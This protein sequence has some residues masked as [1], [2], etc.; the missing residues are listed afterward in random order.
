MGGIDSAKKRRL[1]E[2][3]GILFEGGGLPRMSG[4]VFGWLL[5]S[6]PQHQTAAE[7]AAGVG[8]SKGS[9]STM[10]RMLAQFR[11]IER[12]G[13]PGER[14]AHYRVKPAYWVSMM[15]AKMDFVRR[16]H[17]LAERALDAIDDSDA[18]RTRQLEETRDFHHAFARELTS[19]IERL[20]AGKAGVAGRPARKRTRKP[21]GG[22]RR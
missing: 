7:I 1:I 11:M 16:F 19:M 12:F 21:A 2:D 17:G 18:E 4:R 13:L 5:I 20:S 10:L 8:A 3:F 22:V 15:Q 6:S 14:S 9:M